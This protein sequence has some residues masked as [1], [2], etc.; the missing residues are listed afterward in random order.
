MADLRKFTKLSTNDFER[1]GSTIEYPEELA[2]YN[3]KP[4]LYSILEDQ[5]MANKF[6]EGQEEIDVASRFAKGETEE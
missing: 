5:K 4:E 2:P 1:K 3:K 6:F